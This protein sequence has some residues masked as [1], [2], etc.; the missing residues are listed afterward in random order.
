MPMIAC[1]LLAAAESSSPSRILLSLI[2]ILIF[3]ALV[4][5]ALR[6]QRK[7]RSYLESARIHMAAME[8]KSDR[9]IE[10]LEELNRSSKRP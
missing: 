6:T 10:L 2:P 1:L 5:F 4:F 3:L 8:Q 9:I 7:N